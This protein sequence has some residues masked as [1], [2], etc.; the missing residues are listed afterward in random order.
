MKIIKKLYFFLIFSIAF[1]NI[2]SPYLDIANELLVRKKLAQKLPDVF[3]DSK[4]LEI[5]NKIN[6]IAN[7]D[8]KDTQSQIDFQNFEFHWCY[9]QTYLLSG[10]Q[11]MALQHYRKYKIQLNNN[12]QTIN[13]LFEN[14]ISE[15]EIALKNSQKVL[16][17]EILSL[18][19]NI[20]LSTDSPG[21]EEI[22]KLQLKLNAFNEVNNN[23]QQLFIDG[24][25]GPNTKSAIFDFEENNQYFISDKLIASNSHEYNLDNKYSVKNIFKSNKKQSFSTKVILSKEKIKTIPGTSIAEILEFVVGINVRRQGGFDASANISTLGGTSEQTLILI[26]GLKISNQQTLNHDLDL[27]INIDDIEQIEIYTNPSARSY[28]SGALSGAINIITKKGDSRQTYLSSET[29][30]YSLFNN[31]LMLALPVGN[32]FHN[33]SFSSLESGS[34]GSYS[35]NTAFDKTTFF[36]KYSLEEGKTATNFSYGYLKKG[37]QISNFL[38][39]I[40][41]RQYETN[42]TQFINS[43][44][45]WDFGKNKIESN[46]YWY[47]HRN[48]LA[49]DYNVSAWNTYDNT[50]I[51]LNFNIESETK[52]GFR[53]TDLIL[54]RE[55]NSNSI[56]SDNLR[57]N[58]SITYQQLLIGKLISFDFGLSSNYYKN[59]G[60]FT[61]PGYQISYNIN[62]NANVY[63]KYDNGFRLPSFYERYSNDYMHTGNFDLKNERSNA[64]EYG[65][66]I[67]G[68]AIRITASHFYKNS[69]NV[70]DWYKKN[71]TAWKSTNIENV[72][73]SGHNLQLELYPELI[74]RLN[75]LQALELGYSYLDIE[76][77]GNEID[78]RNVSNYLKH[79]FILSTTY[80][81]PFGINRSWFIRY[82]QPI[83]QDNRIIFDTQVQYSFWRFETFLNINNLFNVQYQDVSNVALP[84]RWTRISLRYNF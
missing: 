49:L 50:E 53:K 83:N 82:E 3:D 22:Q 13:K 42:V 47:D 44:I 27:P 15:L 80:K 24:N 79:Q 51:G 61:S 71:S 33:L 4:F 26:D 38:T 37:N 12:S 43:K 67:Y 74:N 75:F 76:H 52:N 32:S 28:G 62:N 69:T 14:N 16:A 36:Y 48:S 57:D 63:H 39:N 77:N 2:Q 40:L 7:I 11:S 65:I 58:Y 20:K 5:V 56:I 6:S 25:L 41:P 59:I 9:A 31:N 60:W 45:L 34:S 73:S 68:T 18:I 10:N 84:G 78:Y 81:L 70:I 30:D 64:F 17:I 35:N 46:T 54:N 72:L 1:S 23:F 21:I 55:I 29:G 66:Q 19:N 8:P